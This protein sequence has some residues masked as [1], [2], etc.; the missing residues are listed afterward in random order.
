M[1]IA[2]ELSREF[3]NQEFDRT[4][5]AE[6]SDEMERCTRIASLYA[7]MENA[8]CV[9]SDMRTDRSRI[10]Y[11]GFSRTL[12]I[13]APDGRSEEIGS[14]WEEEIL[15]RIH[16]ED[17]SAKYLQER[18]FFR[19]ITHQPKN[20][21]PNYCLLQKLRMKGCDGNY[22][23]VL[24]RLFYISSPVDNSLWLTLCLYN[25]LEME[26]PGPG[27]ILNTVT[28]QLRELNQPDTLRLLSDR[29]R[30]VLTLIDNGMTSKGIARRLSISV[31]T[32]S[33]HRQEIL[34]K[35]H[36]RNSIE[37]CRIARE[38]KIL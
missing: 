31:H 23:P 24:H 21:R 22:L 29:E 18:C 17:L 16:P 3:F 7:R 4:N 10:Y 36:A 8:V 20:R 34:G 5:R 32:V 28:G 19:F 11:G 12:G 27:F 30:E 14:V 33:R 9:L 15:A 6:L 25:P 13:E 26:L 37:A 1:E 35:L 38:L 2:K